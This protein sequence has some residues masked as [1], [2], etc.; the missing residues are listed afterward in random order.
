VALASERI[1]PAFALGSVYIALIARI[2][3]AAMLEVL[4]KDYMRKARA[5]GMGPD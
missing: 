5:K 4:P 1:L 3:A 2:N